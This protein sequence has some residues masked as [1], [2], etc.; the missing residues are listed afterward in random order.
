MA[1]QK[2]NA[3][4]VKELRELSAALALHGTE[5][6]QLEPARTSL[7]KL[8]SEIDELSPQQ[9][10]HR[11]NKQKVSQQLQERILGGAKLATVIR[12]TLK[13]HYGNRSEDLVKYGLQPFRGRTRRQTAPEGPSTPEEPTVKPAVTPSSDPKE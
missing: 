4:V 13:E 11:S 12:F 1:G 2:S 8:L 3:E 6:P 7:D 10:F 5:V 9:T